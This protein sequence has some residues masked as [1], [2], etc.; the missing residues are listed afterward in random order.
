ME[1][2]KDTIERLTK[3]KYCFKFLYILS[4]LK[5]PW[6]MVILVTR[7]YSPFYINKKTYVFKYV[8]F[9]VSSA[10]INP[11][12]WTCKIKVNN[13]TLILRG[14]QKVLR[15][16]CLLQLLQ[17]CKYNFIASLQQNKSYIEMCHYWEISQILTGIPC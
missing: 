13:K 2:G 6:I 8:I 3:P 5:V 9:W 4:C 1:K 11:N 12:E 7:M 15:V 14:Y 10:S 16:H 17:F